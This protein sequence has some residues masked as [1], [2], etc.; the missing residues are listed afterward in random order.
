MP[1]HYEIE[2]DALYIEG[3]EAGIEQATHAL[4]MRLLRKGELPKETIAS[5]AEVDMEFVLQ[6]EQALLQGGG[7]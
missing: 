2:T 1:I 4:I 7:N 6:I 3:K 5:V